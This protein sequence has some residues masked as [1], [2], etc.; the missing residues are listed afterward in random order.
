MLAEIRFPIVQTVLDMREVGTWEYA[1]C[2][3]NTRSPTW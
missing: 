2:S 1:E 3:L